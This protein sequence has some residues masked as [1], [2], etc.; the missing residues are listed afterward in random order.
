[1]EQVL[2]GL[3]VNHGQDRKEGGIKQQMRIGDVGADMGQIG[4]ISGRVEDDALGAITLRAGV[5]DL[6]HAP[7]GQINHRDGT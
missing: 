3:Q 7:L 2:V 5:N 4:A 6:K 1:M